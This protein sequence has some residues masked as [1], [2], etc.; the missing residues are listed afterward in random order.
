MAPLTM[1]MVGLAEPDGSWQEC[2]LAAL[3]TLPLCVVAQYFNG[4]LGEA[5]LSIE[6]FLLVCFVFSPLFVLR[7]RRVGK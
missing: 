3:S 2:V 1:I 5:C 6:T 4:G 7:A